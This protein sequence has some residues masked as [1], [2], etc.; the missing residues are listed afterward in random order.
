M[1]HDHPIFDQ[2]L[3]GLKQAKAIFLSNKFGSLCIIKLKPR[4][5]L[6][7]PITIKVVRSNPVQVRCTRYNIML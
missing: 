5:T 7:V 2:N 1:N 3:R 4:K 6:S